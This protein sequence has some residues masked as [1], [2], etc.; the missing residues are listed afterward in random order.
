M[1]RI[2]VPNSYTWY[3]KGDAAIAIG[4]FYALRKHIP[5]ADITLLSSTPEIDA[6]KYRK[7]KA[8]VLRSL[9]TLSPTDNSPK[10]VKGI[11]LIAK[12][13]KYSLWSKLR[14]PVDPDERQ[15]LSAYAE[16]DI[17]VSCGG[18]FLGGYGIIAGLASFLHLYG[19]YFAK[20]LGKPVIIYGQSVEQL[21]NILVSTAT[22]FVLNRVDLI[23]VREGVSYDYL[24]SLGIKPKVILTADAAF[25]VKSISTEESL[26]LLAEENIYSEQRPL[27]GMTVRHWNFPGYSDGKTRFSNYLEVVTAT[28]EWLI[29]KMNATVVL[30]PQVIYSPK[31]DDRIVSS[32]IVSKIKHKANIRVLTKDYSPEELKGTIGQMDLFI[33]TRMHSNI[34]ALSNG[35]PTIAISYQ[36]KTD[37]IMNML[38]MSQYVLDMANLTFDDM[39]RLIQVAWNS[40]ESISSS[41]KSKIREVQKQALYNAALVKDMLHTK[42]RGLDNV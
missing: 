19:I 13:I 15:I 11:R 2:L 42:A 9:L 41:L 7:Y 36:K 5:N 22:K 12:A 4:M 32:E 37:G 35:I 26:R 14:F 20:L 21:G 1:T 17:V 33:G 30:F 29:S 3:E 10:L 8:K 40:R 34:F 24:K 18:G 16:A 25:L 27:V 28:I 6:Q 39:V 31:D 38:G 23:T